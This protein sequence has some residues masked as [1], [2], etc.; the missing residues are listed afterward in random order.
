[1]APIPISAKTTA[2]MIGATFAAVAVEAAEATHAMASK[3]RKRGRNGALGGTERKG[4]LVRVSQ[5]MYLCFIYVSVSMFPRRHHDNVS[6]EGSKH[7][8]ERRH[9][10]QPKNG[11]LRAELGKYYPLGGGFIKMER[12]FKYLLNLKRFTNI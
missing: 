4:Q 9:L 6:G 10:T 7:N 5:T 8:T 11:P 12:I 3:R 1:M 2:I